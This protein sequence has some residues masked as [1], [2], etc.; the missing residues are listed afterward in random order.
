MKRQL[1]ALA[2]MAFLLAAS[3]PLSGCK[4]NG[5]SSSP[6]SAVSGM[7]STPSSGTSNSG[8]P[9]GERWT[10]NEFIISTLVGIPSGANDAQNDRAV[11]YH[12]E[13]NFNMIELCNFSD[14][15]MLLA[16]ETCKKYGVSALPSDISFTD[17][18]VTEEQIKERMKFYEPYADTIRGF[19]IRDEPAYDTELYQLL[20]ER[21]DLVRSLAPTKLMFMNL[22]PSYGNYTWASE[23]GDG[24][25]SQFAKYCNDF[26]AATDPDV[27]SVDH[28]V[29][30]NN[31]ACIAN[32]SV[33]DLWRDWG[34]FR[35][36]SIETGKPFWCYIQSLGVFMH[37]KGIGGMT[38]EKIAFQLNS[39]IAYGVKGISYYNS[40]AS[41]I[42]ER[43]YKTELFDGVKEANRQALLFG[44]YLLNKDYGKLYHTSMLEKAEKH[45]YTDK[46]SESDLLAALPDNAL[47]STFT[48]D[49]ARTYLMIVNRS[50]EAAMEGTIV[51][52]DTKPIGMLDTASGEEKAVSTSADRIAVSLPA[53]GAAL[54]MIG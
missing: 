36:R 35:K 31:E 51:L 42:D 46:L 3:L 11:K 33:N 21:A 2:A 34:F 15:E 50:Y 44:N 30:F 20:R 16:L 19:L 22:F 54:Y 24:N 1:T 39:A 25:D 48:D 27:L 17:P 13:A 12:K 10:P 37:D 8:F 53:G 26:F 6:S 45:Y 18:N 4:D 41:V 47:V 52:K 9:D 5:D 7:D 28:Y 32:L 40:L 49:T 14:K 29:F 23:T 38:P 43:A